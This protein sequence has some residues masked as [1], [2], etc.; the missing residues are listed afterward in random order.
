MASSK[1]LIFNQEILI[2][3]PMLLGST[4]GQ[5][6]FCIQD[7]MGLLTEFYGNTTCDYFNVAELLRLPQFPVPHA[8]QLG[9]RLKE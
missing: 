6:D 3:S 4:Q 2:T 1:Y 7:L 5:K 8:C 9:M